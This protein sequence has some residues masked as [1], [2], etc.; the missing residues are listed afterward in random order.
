ATHELQHRV[1]AL[2]SVD[3]FKSLSDDEIHH[4]AEQTVPAPFGKGEVITHQGAQAHW[5]YIVVD[6]TVD[7]FVETDQ[8]QTVKV[9]QI[10][11]GQC[12]GEWG[13]MTGEPR[14]ATV[15]AN[16]KVDCFKLGKDGFTELIQKRPN[17]VEELSQVL[18]ARRMERD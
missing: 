18:T 3:I 7:V 10:G 13:L 4:L 8:K 6:G 9:G 1:D 15:I 16:T 17:I 11:A 14:D 5:L 2:R 12:F